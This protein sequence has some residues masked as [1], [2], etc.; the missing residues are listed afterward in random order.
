ML[1]EWF[2]WIFIA[3]GIGFAVDGFGSVLIGGGQYHNVLF[4]GERYVRAAAGVTLIILG[5]VSAFV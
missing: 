3:F 2:N 5:I 4:D 1:F